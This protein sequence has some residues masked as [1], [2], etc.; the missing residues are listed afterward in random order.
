MGVLLTPHVFCISYCRFVKKF[1]RIP[2]TDFVQTVEWKVKFC[3][4][5]ND[6]LPFGGLFC[7]N[8]FN[9]NQL[10]YNSASKHPKHY[11]GGQRFDSCKHLTATLA[12]E[13]IDASLHLSIMTFFKFQ[14]QCG[15]QSTSVFV[16]VQ[17]VLVSSFHSLKVYCKLHKFYRKVLLGYTSLWCYRAVRREK[18]ETIAFI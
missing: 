7:W 3:I 14:I 12:E 16:F 6:Q 11:K 17:N 4:Y 5:F 2:V 8:A 13:L 10:L 18:N 15:H 9:F 1:G